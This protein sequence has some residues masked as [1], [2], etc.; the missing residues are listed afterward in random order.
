ME[1]MS[2]TKTPPPPQYQL[3]AALCPTDVFKNMS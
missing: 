3:V 2:Q 1:Y